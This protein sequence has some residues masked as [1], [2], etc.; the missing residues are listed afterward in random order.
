MGLNLRRRTP[1]ERAQTPVERRVARIA[2]PDLQAWAEQALSA[3]G[4]SLRDFQRSQADAD[5][6]EAE[7]G[8]EAL[9]AVVRELRRRTSVT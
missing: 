3:L 4:R 2:T 1:E 6:R 8:A 9:L 7:M 5:L